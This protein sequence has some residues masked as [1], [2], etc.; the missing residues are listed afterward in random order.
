[1]FNEFCLGRQEN[2]EFWK[3]FLQDWLN[4]SSDLDDLR[5]KLQLSSEFLVD[6]KCTVCMGTEDQTINSILIEHNY[7]FILFLYVDTHSTRFS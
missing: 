3:D 4:L 5:S 6:V 2:K 7:T 1:M